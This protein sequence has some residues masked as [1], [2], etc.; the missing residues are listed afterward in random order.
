MKNSKIQF[1][2]QIFIPMGAV[3]GVAKNAPYRDL[4]SQI[5]LQLRA[6]GFNERMY[7][8]W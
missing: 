7:E 4:F 1:V 6:Q 3:L 8:K 5:I 2:E